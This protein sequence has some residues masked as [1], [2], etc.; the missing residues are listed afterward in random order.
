MELYFIELLKALL[1]RYIFKTDHKKPL[2]DPGGRRRGA[3]PTGSI[4]FIFAYIF[5]KKVYALEVGAPPNGSAAPPPP[6]PPRVILDPP[7]G[8]LQKCGLIIDL[9]RVWASFTLNAYES[10]VAK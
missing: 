3:P 10:D 6:P 4:S 1:F 7:L 8:T 5:A 2:A 9:K